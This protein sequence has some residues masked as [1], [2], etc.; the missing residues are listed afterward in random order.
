MIITP[1]TRLDSVKEYYFSIK[2]KQLRSLLAEGKEIINLGIGS[3]DLAPDGTVVQA[4]V[5]TATTP[6]NHGYQSYVGLPEFRAQ[7]AA[8]YKRIYN[9]EVDKASEILPLIGSK[10]GIMH[11]SMAFLNKGDKVLIP[12]PGYPTYASVSDLVQADVVAYSLND[13]WQ[14]DMEELKKHTDAKILWVNYPNMPTGTRADKKVLKELIAFCKENKI[15]LVNDNPYSLILN[16]E[17]PF[18]IFQLEGAR[19]V[20]LE[21]NSMSKSHNMAGWRVGMLVGDQAYI[22]TILKVKSNMDSGMFKGTQYAAMEG[23][24]LDL[25]WHQDQNKIY[26]TRRDIA[27]DIFDALDIGYSRDIVGMFVWGKVPDGVTN[28]EKFV[29]EILDKTEVFITPGFIFG[30]KG[31]RYIRI[32]LCSKENVLVTALKRIQSW[33]AS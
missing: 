27:W 28:T 29:D 2:L 12:N 8:W 1:A 23:L 26:A 18:S 3:P 19:E 16:D 21:L 5:D 22:Q 32:S 33:K 20:A 9:I 4:M 14:P 25:K 24:K 11:I 31:E 13:K 10:E 17:E 30:S 7:I 6:S 15:L